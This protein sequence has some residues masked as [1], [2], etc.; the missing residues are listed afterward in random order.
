MNQWRPGHS[1]TTRDVIQDLIVALKPYNIRLMLYIHVT[2]GHDFTEEEQ[3]ATGWNDPTDN[4]AKWNNFV[5]DMVTEIGNRYGKGIDGY[6][7]DM[8]TEDYFQDMIDKQRLRQSLLAGN[9]DRV[10][11]GNGGGGDTPAS[12]AGGAT[13]YEAREYYPSLDF[14][15]WTSTENQT[16]TVIATDGNWWVTTAVGKSDLKYSPEDMFRFTI[17]EAGTNQ[18]GGGM[19]WAVGCYVGSSTLWEDGIKIGLQ[20]LGN[21]IESVSPSIKNVYPSTSY[22]TPSGASL[23]TIS[24]GIV[25]TKSIDDMVE[26]IH[27]LNPPSVGNIL[28]L[29]APKD[30]KVFRKALLLKNGHVVSIKQTKNSLVLTLDKSDA[31]DILDTVIKLE[32]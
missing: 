19:N 17:L 27:V 13:D 5:N 14:N 8:T 20:R 21:Y 3:M 18:N 28:I 2:D 25:A 10:V 1:S 11:V 23:N 9:L 15:T 29:S 16:A 6:W 24:S 31:W 26:Y 12:V 4:Y 30:S 32:I 22:I 7:L